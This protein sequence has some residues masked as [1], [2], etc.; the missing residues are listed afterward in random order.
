VMRAELIEGRDEL[1]QECHG[2]R[3]GFSPGPATPRADRD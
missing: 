1:L 3:P 2:G